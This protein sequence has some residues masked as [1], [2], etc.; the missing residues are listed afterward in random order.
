MDREQQ[1][2][3]HLAATSEGIGPKQDR[4]WTVYGGLKINNSNDLEIR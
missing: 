1:E 4:E 2:V 3:D